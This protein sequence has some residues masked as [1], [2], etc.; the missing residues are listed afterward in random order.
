MAGRRTS[1]IDDLFAEVNAQYD[2]ALVPPLPNLRTSDGETN[3][4]TTLL[5][6][7]VVTQGATKNKQDEEAKQRARQAGNERRKLKELQQQLHR[8]SL[9]KEKLKR[10][11]IA[12]YNKALGVLKRKEALAKGLR[13]P[14]KGE[15]PADFQKRRHEFKKMLVGDFTSLEKPAALS[16]KH[17]KFRLEPVLQFW[18]PQFKEERPSTQ[19]RQEV[20]EGNIRRHKNVKKAIQRQRWVKMLNSSNF[21][22]K[23]VDNMAKIRAKNSNKL[24]TLSALMQQQN[25]STNTGD[26]LSQFL[27]KQAKEGD[28]EK[29]GVGKVLD[30]DVRMAMAN[31]VRERERE[32]SVGIGEQADV[33][34]AA[35]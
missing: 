34:S 16:M 15:H 4:H 8:E 1:V 23:Q 27:V 3:H 22:S 18:M 17:E 21:S 25:Y 7:N 31:R 12:E 28:D 26:S 35:C 30:V 9:K 10:R 14:I 2:H 29:K 6:W 5:G 11:E 20:H 24:G 32:R 33:T 13:R 19:Q